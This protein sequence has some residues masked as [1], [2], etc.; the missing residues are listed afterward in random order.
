M[1]FTVSLAACMLDEHYPDWPGMLRDAGA[2]MYAA[3]SAGRNRVVLFTPAAAQ[4]S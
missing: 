2:A 4:G 1:H 3:R